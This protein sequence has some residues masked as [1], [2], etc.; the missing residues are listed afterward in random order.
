MTI[1]SDDRKTDVALPD[2]EPVGSLV[3]EIL[4]ILGNAD[5]GGTAFALAAT[6]GT[7]IDFDRTLSDQGVAQGALLRLTTFDEAPQP[8]ETVDLTDVAAVRAQERTDRWRPWAYTAVL[9]MMVAALGF[10]LGF[11]SATSLGL[12]TTGVV[13][14]I[15][16]ALSAGLARLGI[17]RLSWV[18]VSLGLGTQAAFITVLAIY[19][20]PLELALAAFVALGLSVSIHLGMGRQQRSAMTGGALGTLVAGAPLLSLLAGA[21]T[22]TTYTLTAVLGTVLIGVLPGIALTVAGLAQL[23]DR[24]IHGNA[25]LRNNVDAAVDNSYA[26]LSWT[27]VMVCGPVS[28]GLVHLISDDGPWRLALA[29]ALISVV[30]LRS[31]TVPLIPQRFS[32]LLAAGIPTSL[33]L[34]NTHLVSDAARTSTAFVLLGCT[35]A[36][37]VL[38]PP[39]VVQARI[40]RSLDIM[41]LVAVLV[42]LTSVLGL[43]GVYND[44]LEVFQ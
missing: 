40:R 5:P 37:A 33:W 8:P 41:E 7:E 35:F 38:H 1:A 23:D 10:F 15:V 13:A 17:N 4:D 24:V 34:V 3:P 12:L 18:V 31:R 2:D 25:V 19:L 39:R 22:T 28:I 32:L 42:V 21:D 29:A 11:Q 9:A 26:V 36:L 27:L 16:L 14:V 6:S 20:P 30:A 44:L 43:L